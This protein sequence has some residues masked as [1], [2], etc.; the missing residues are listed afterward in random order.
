MSGGF[1][2]FILEQ[3]PRSKN[4]HVDSLATLATMSREKLPRIILA[5]DLVSLAYDMQVPI[6]VH[7]HEWVLVGWTHWLHILQMEPYLRIELRRIRSEERCQGFGCLR[8][9]SCTS[10][11]ILVRI[12]YASI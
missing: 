6:R 3:V 10:V 12:Y 5:E 9:K 7:P 8:I 2:S 4:S 1:H 11:H